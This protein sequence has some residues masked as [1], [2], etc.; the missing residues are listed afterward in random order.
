MNQVYLSTEI[1]F[2]VTAWTYMYLWEKLEHL[3][4]CQEFDT[5]ALTGQTKIHQGVSIFHQGE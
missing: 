2:H 3:S 4:V 1:Q 5:K